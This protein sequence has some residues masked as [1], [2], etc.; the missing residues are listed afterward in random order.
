VPS[1]LPIPAESYVLVLRLGKED[2]E[3]I[4]DKTNREVLTDLRNQKPRILAARKLQSGD[5]RVFTALQMERDRLLK[6]LG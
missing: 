1:L 5:I 4:K 3:E 6:D 2:Q